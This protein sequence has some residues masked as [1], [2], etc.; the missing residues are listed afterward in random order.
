V[1][2]Q[3]LRWRKGAG[4]RRGAVAVRLVHDL[5]AE[6]GAH[7]EACPR[8]G[9]APHRAHVQHRADAD[10]QLPVPLAGQALDGLQRAGHRHRHLDGADAARVQRPRDGEHVV[11]A[12]QA[13]HRQRA[14]RRDALDDGV[15]LRGSGWRLGQGHLP[16]SNVR[17]G[18]V[19]I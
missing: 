1:G 12:G 6:H 11:R 17:K 5:A 2:V 3:D 13:H 16:R 19:S 4:E 18:V 10:Q 15:A 9:R 14:E 7:D 8:V